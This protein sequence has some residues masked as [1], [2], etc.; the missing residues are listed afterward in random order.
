MSDKCPHHWQ[1][2][3]AAGPVSIGICK[4]CGE[5][6]E[7]KNFISEPPKPQIRLN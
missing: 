1:I 3:K 4:L 6:K 7:F 5:K 2:E